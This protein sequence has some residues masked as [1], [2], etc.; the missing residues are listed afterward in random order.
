MYHNDAIANI[1][2]LGNIQKRFRVT[3]DSRRRN[4]VT[5]HLDDGTARYFHPTTKGL[6]VSQVTRMSQSSSAAMRS[7]VKE[8]KKGFTRREIENA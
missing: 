5:V 1:L 6:Y 2:L 3:S 7:T 4:Y 8:N